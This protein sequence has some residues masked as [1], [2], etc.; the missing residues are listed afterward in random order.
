MRLRRVA[1]LA[2]LPV[3]G[4]P[5]LLTP[6]PSAAAVQVAA[7][8]TQ[9]L[10]ELRLREREAAGDLENSSQQVQAAGAALRA[11]E[12]QLPGARRAVAEAKGELAGA[13]AKAAA[14]TAEVRRAEAEAAAAAREVERASSKVE[15]GRAEVGRL[16]RRT[17]QRG[18]LS[19]LR[20]VMEAGEPQDALLRA[21]M[22]RSVFRTQNDSLSRLTA[23][24]L[25]LAGT[26]A[27]LAAD[28]RALEQ[29]R[30]EAE[31]V[32]ARA[33]EVAV[34]AEQAARKVEDLAAQ[35]KA[36]LAQAEK[37]R[38]EDLQDYRE[39]QA[40]SA[41][42]AERIRKAAAKAAAERAAAERRRK[43]AEE[44]ERKK[45]ERAGQ[46]P[47]R[48]EP[49][50]DRMLW[51]APGRL[52][53]RYGY[54]THPIYGDRRFHAGIDIGGGLGAR[55]SAS[56]GGYV[57]YAGYASGYGTLVVISHGT[58]GGRDLSTAYAHMGELTVRE[59]QT[60]TKGQKVGEIGNEGNSTGPHLHFEVRLN[61]DPV[62]PLDYVDPP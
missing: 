36:V 35:R 20:D 15:E 53:S 41:A 6:A 7:P 39:A 22:L 47:S 5:F 59:G 43:A 29:A 25:A 54:R 21:G 2:L 52:T 55:V 23:D 24:R 30:A 60:V 18:R 4:L 32:A 9:S 34:R 50:S 10:E 49:R 38:A 42:L 46:K 40:A 11:V 14:A 56:D 8:R 12:Q 51:P 27:D 61:G 58:V 19:D 44:A 31:R 33:R 57:T 1:A 16:A 17:Y 37:H 3:A 62:D 28:E 13:R 26:R 45:R 48:S